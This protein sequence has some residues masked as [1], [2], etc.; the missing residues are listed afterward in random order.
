ME[1]LLVM[2]LSGSVMTLICL[3]LW[4][5]W[6]NM[7]SAR[8]YYMLAKAAVLYYLIPLPFL[9]RWYRGVIRVVFPEKEMEIARILL[10]RT[11]YAVHTDEGIYV[12]TY[13]ECQIIIVS[14]WLSVAVILMA[15]RL[16]KYLRTARWIAGY[17]S[18]KMTDQQK[19]YLSGL[20]K[21]YR[22]RRHVLLYQ[23]M[24]GEPSMTFGVYRPVIICG[25][26]VGSREAELLIR[27][28]LVHIR[29]WDALWKM[30]MQLVVF[31]HW[32]SPV[33]WILY[34]MFDR[35]CELSCDETVMDGKS[36]EE[37]EEY[38]RLL[39]AEAQEEG[40]TK[41]PSLRWEGGFGDNIR[42]IRERVEN[43]MKKKRWNRFTAGVLV[44]TLVFANS[45][46]VFAYKDTFHEIVPED[47]S[48]EEIE[49]VLESDTFLFTPDGMDG[50]VMQ[51]F[52]IPEIDEIQYDRQFTDEEGNI[53]P[54]PD[55]V[56]Y[57]GCDHT[58]VSG[59]ETRHNTNSDGSCDVT[60]Y[61][62]QRCSKCG[63]VVQGDYIASYHYAVCPH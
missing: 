21:E 18:L 11:N 34:F 33:M 19:A 53:Y 40:K 54:V 62:A 22:I 25:K 45:I 5:L 36:E 26:E 46:T 27:H 32:W 2:T 24:A 63:L 42:E 41:K 9:K 39:I 23:E 7:V 35:L 30:L 55:I 28:E 8:I 16:V 10:T 20:R 38:A 49:S 52:E 43:L 56:P 48:Q 6:R 12:N 60:Q 29:R 1:Y 61:R 50:E 51:D 58:Y 59:T 3:F 57:F 17:T 44:A 13:A 31:I 15:A 37:V 4:C 14:V 47:V